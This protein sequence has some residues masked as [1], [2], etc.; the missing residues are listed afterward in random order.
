MKC[1]EFSRTGLARVPSSKVKYSPKRKSTL[2]IIKAPN[3]RWRTVLAVFTI[4]WPLVKP[5]EGIG[6]PAEAQPATLRAKRMLLA[7]RF[8]NI[9]LTF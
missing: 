1:I 9:G 7:F 2:K 6:A 5:R 4:G 3:R 8:K